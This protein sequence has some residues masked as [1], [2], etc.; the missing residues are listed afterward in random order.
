MTRCTVEGREY[1]VNSNLGRNLCGS[2][3]FDLCLTYGRHSTDHRLRFEAAASVSRGSPWVLDIQVDDELRARMP[4]A[5]SV[6]ASTVGAVAGAAAA[7]VGLSQLAGM[8]PE[9]ISLAA[10]AAYGSL[11]S[12]PLAALAARVPAAIAT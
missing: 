5:I 4:S 7:A 1:E 11:G 10:V 3:R 6:A 8:E 2:G 12:V 9:V